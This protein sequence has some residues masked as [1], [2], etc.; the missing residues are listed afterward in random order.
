MRTGF[1]PGEFVLRH[2]GAVPRQYSGP[3]RFAGVE[4]RFEIHQAPEEHRAPQD[5]Q[6]GISL[7][8]KYWA[9]KRTFRQLPMT[10][11]PVK[12]SVGTSLKNHPLVRAL[13]KH[14]DLGLW[15]TQPTIESIS[16]LISATGEDHAR[17]QALRDQWLPDLI[18]G[19]PT[20][21]DL[22]TAL[23][24]LSKHLICH[25]GG[26]PRTS[27]PA[28]L[29]LTLLKA[30]RHP[31]PDMWSVMTRLNHWLPRG[32]DLFD[33]P[34]TAE[35]PASR[36][37][38]INEM[39]TRIEGDPT[40][41]LLLTTS[42]RSAV[43]DL[44]IHLLRLPV[45][46]AS[47]E[48]ETAALLRN[49]GSR[50]PCQA[51]AA[52][53]L[54]ALEHPNFPRDEASTHGVLNYLA[55]GYDSVY[56]DLAFRVQKEE[57]SPE[58]LQYLHALNGDENAVV[59][60]MPHWLTGTSPEPV[61]TWLNQVERHQDLLTKHSRSASRHPNEAEML[62]LLR[63]PK[64]PLDPNAHRKIQWKAISALTSITRFSEA[65]IK[66]SSPEM[67]KLWSNLGLLTHGFRY[68]RF[69][70]QGGDQSLLAAFGFK[71]S[72]KTIENKEAWPFG[73]GFVLGPERLKACGLDPNLHI[74]FFRGYLLASHP[75]QGTLLIRNSS[76]EF[77]RETLPHPA[78]YSPKTQNVV[79]LD[80]KKKD[81]ASDQGWRP[82]LTPELY[83]E[84]TGTVGPMRELS[85]A[86]MKVKGAYRQW[87]FD[88]RA[89]DEEGSFI[90]DQSP[91]FKPMMA[92]LREWAM[93]RDFGWKDDPPVLA[94]VH[95]DYPPYKP[96]ATFPLTPRHLKQVA[97]HLDGTWDQE[98]VPPALRAKTDWIQFLQTGV[99]KRAELVLLDAR[100]IKHKKQAPQR[101]D[102]P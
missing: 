9:L 34:K 36:W 98:G 38:R 24:I 99:E 84:N 76:P 4:E 65:G 61:L 79:R 5:Q 3:I 90:G 56:G 51:M 11:F 33:S 54:L 69:D 10:D 78:Y 59:K 97:G 16:A 77:G 53:A 52:C 75:D 26:E 74:A 85:E 43:A 32:H 18:N 82:I 89:F 87:K 42:A 80:P 19:M 100:Q 31:A 68:W 62:L 8:L 48:K 21:E 15:S 2:S 71:P 45:T 6:L 72:E 101:E 44:V 7:Q 66:L 94:F 58:D 92:Q 47:W 95:P 60:L 14:P 88:A 93:Y 81:L 22:K 25:N 64:D 67:V 39:M 57:I 37:S 28:S 23:Q 35:I 55:R 96:Y 27:D 91:G 40:D 29:V 102:T 46:E 73:N 86:L 70:A 63:S 12:L 13:L 17:R 41:S 30:A 20:G 50:T 1:V 49:R 83:R